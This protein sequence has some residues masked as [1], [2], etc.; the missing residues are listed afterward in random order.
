MADD[1]AKKSGYEYLAA[2]SRAMQHA[3][4][5]VDARGAAVNVD[6]DP[7]NASP[8]LATHHIQLTYGRATRTIAVDHETFMND[9]FF[10]TLVLHQIEAAI[11]DLAASA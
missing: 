4:R 6:I 10:R 7:V 1:L 8:Y 3:V 2:C 11:D 5:L 9:E